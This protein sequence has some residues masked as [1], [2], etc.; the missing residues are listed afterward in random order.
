MNAYLRHFAG[1]LI[2]L[3]LPTLLCLLPFG[4]GAFHWSR[5]RVMAAYGAA[6]VLLSA[7]FPLA[8]QLMPLMPFEQP[9]VLSNLY[10]LLALGLFTAAYFVI[11][12]AEA[13]KKL[14]VLVLALFYAATQ[15]LLVN[16]A[17]PLFPM[18]ELPDA[19]PPLT[20]LLY[21]VTAA[22]MFPPAALMMRGTVRDY[23][24]EMELSGIRREFRA[25]LSVTLLYFVM[26]VLYSSRPDSQIGAFWWWVTPPL[27]F[28]IA[29][30]CIFYRTLFREA[31]RRR[32]E[33]E[34]RRTVQLQQLQY[35]KIAQEMEAA[36]RMRHDLRHH[37]VALEGMLEGGN[38]LAMR[39]Y[40]AA[41]QDGAGGRGSE[42]FCRNMTVNAL[43]QYYVEQARQLGARCEVRADCGDVPIAPA[44]LT[45][46]LG[47]ALENA[48]RAC[49]ET[50]HPFLTVDLG[51][52]SGSLVVQVVNACASVRQRGGIAPVGGFLPAE[53][54][55]STREGGGHGLESLSIT[56]QKYGGDARF[57]YD[58][59]AG[60]F[61]TRVRLNLYPEDSNNDH[62]WG[63]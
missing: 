40:L 27:L 43:L 21:A 56:A 55:E 51:V 26:L 59:A 35:D 16:L 61:T 41:L 6:A 52:L 63:G 42:V 22:V 3:G 24:A 49:G 60:T 36:R 8:R 15:Y 10:M 1:F 25:V 12:R 58:A 38:I 57:R 37:L 19:Y 53:A 20:L 4:A 62:G 11:I 33:S 23:L 32:R 34:L 9:T 17:S 5:G 18:G 28:A 7:L 39:D 54:F 29:L 31:V 48:V 30:L 44:D 2:Q 45:V 46:L 47:N 50:P 14:I 13:V